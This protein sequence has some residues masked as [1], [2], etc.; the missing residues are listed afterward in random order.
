MSACL[1]VESHG[2]LANVES[3]KYDD[4]HNC[5]ALNI[6]LLYSALQVEIGEPS[7][8]SSCVYFHLCTNILWEGVNPSPPPSYGLNNNLYLENSLL[9][10]EKIVNAIFTFKKNSKGLISHKK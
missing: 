6:F 3:L 5:L 1:D 7:S 10:T 8:N 4:I 2:S 9:F